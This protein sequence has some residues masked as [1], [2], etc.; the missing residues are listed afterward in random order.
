MRTTLFTAFLVFIISGAA[1]GQSPTTSSPVSAP[2]DSTTAATDTTKEVK[3]AAVDSPSATLRPVTVTGNSSSRSA[4]IRLSSSTGTKIPT[5]LRD[6]PQAMSVINRGLI[7]DQSMQNL[8]DVV[9]YVP[10]ITMG[11]G[12]GNRDQPTIRGNSTTADFYI[13]GVRDD[14]QYFRDLYNVDRV[15]ALKG[16]NAMIFGRG[17]G[18]GVINRV[19]KEASWSPIGELTLQGG[20][21]LNRRVS[22]D[23]GRALND[24]LAARF[25]GLYENSHTFREYVRVRRQGI[26]P[27]FSIGAPANA[28]H[29]QFG[30][31]NFLDY[32]TA[33]R[34]IP[35]FGNTPLDTD[36]ST[37]FGNPEA[38]FSRTRV[39]G[40]SLSVWHS[41]AAGLAINNQTRFTA[42]DKMYQ[43]VLPGAVTANGANVSLSA[44]NNSHRRANIFNQTDLTYALRQ[45]PLAHTFLVGAEVGR[46]TTDNFRNTGFF[47]DTAA[48]LSVAV[49]A[50]TTLAPVSFRQTATDANNRVTVNTSSIYAQDQVELTSYLRLI[51]GLRYESFDLRFHDNRTG[52][53]LARHDAMPSPRVGMVIKP[54]EAASLYASYS[55]SY[56]P[57]SGDQFSSLTN[58]TEALDPEKFIN[59]EAGAKWD[60]ADR[61]ALTAAVYRLDRTN[62]RA[63]SPSDPSILVQTGRQRSQGY[64]LGITGQPTV[65]WSVSGGFTRQSSLIT[66]T[67]AAA[68]A[69]ASVPLVPATTFSLWNKYQ[70]APGFAFA[71]GAVYQEA[72]YAAIS[73]TVKLPAFTRFDG[74][75]YYSLTKDVSAQVNVENILN[76]EYYPLANGNNNITPGAPRSIRATL[77]THF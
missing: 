15:E 66:S 43:N 75:V 59:V 44:Y 40:G 74:G 3:P 58:V 51:A 56:L 37:F 31:E 63:P 71:L 30:Y 50:P 27:T 10:G 62:T 39:N 64:E 73:N 68:A 8:G 69:G 70:M 60:V 28:T 22:I 57:S 34:G 2:G 46:Q 33:D 6:I 52:L 12:E 29:V 65:A 23:A 19:M 77:T 48:T 13:D 7:A 67:T 53:N 25:N 61:L 54:V 4:Y 55:V 21:Y 18:G 36:I 26:N 47:N 1:A 24:V 5:L 41:F 42:Y 45:G 76:A 17:G 16:P 20:S 9:R 38:N 72:M 49:S 35:S 14:A 32:R 11:Q